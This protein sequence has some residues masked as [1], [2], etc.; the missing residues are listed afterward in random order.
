MISCTGRDRFMLIFCPVG[1]PMAAR[2]LSMQVLVS[3]TTIVCTARYGQ[4]GLNQLLH[5]QGTRTRYR[6]R[7]AAT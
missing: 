6:L 4:T 2:Q 3:H 7:E 5:M 1:L